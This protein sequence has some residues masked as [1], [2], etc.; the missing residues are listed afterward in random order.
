[1][2]GHLNSEWTYTVA[3]PPPTVPLVR[4][5]PHHIHNM[6]PLSACAELK[7]PLYKPYKLYLSYVLT[8]ISYYKACHCI[9]LYILLYIY[10]HIYSYPVILYSI[11][12]L[13]RFY[14]ISVFYICICVFSFLTFFRSFHLSFWFTLLFSSSSSFVIWFNYVKY[15]LYIYISIYIYIYMFDFDSCVTIYLPIEKRLPIF[16][17]LSNDISSRW[18]KLKQSDCT[19]CYLFF[20]FRKMT[21]TKNV[22]IISHLFICLLHFS[23]YFCIHQL[24][25]WYL[26]LKPKNKLKYTK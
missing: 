24:Q 22:H 19:I 13:V 17:K 26:N 7:L 4:A 16:E 14:L 3:P 25:K 18:D 6:H 23:P 12:N 8:T 21:T 11:Q 15:I 9:F 10:V 2:Q 20:S 5:L 1:M